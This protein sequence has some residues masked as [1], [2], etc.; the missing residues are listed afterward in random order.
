MKRLRLVTVSI[1]DND[2]FLSFKIARKDR[3]KES[4][5]SYL[6]SPIGEDADHTSGKD[7]LGLVSFLIAYTI[8]I[9]DIQLN[10]FQFLNNDLL[11][12]KYVIRNKRNT[13]CSYLKIIIN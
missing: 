9:S 12:H 13:S 4:K 7:I 3:N 1:M 2:K 6:P 8:R 5:I 10:C 11:R